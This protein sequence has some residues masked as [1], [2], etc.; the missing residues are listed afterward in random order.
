MPNFKTKKKIKPKSELMKN[1][2][3]TK[4]SLKNERKIIN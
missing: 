1:I 4:F 3:K 2:F